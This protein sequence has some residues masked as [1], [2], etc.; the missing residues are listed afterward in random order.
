MRVIETIAELREWRR[1]VGQ[2]DV[3]FVPTMGAL[4]DGHRSL[5]KL[6]RD[7]AD[8]LAVSI[9]VN[10]LQF[11]PNE[12]LAKYPRTLEADLDACRAEGVDLV[13]APSVEEMYG[14]VRL[15][16]VGAGRMG[17]ILE[18]ASRPGHFDGVLT[19]VAKL[20]NLVKPDFAVFGQ[21]DAQQLACIRRMV[22]DLNFD[23]DIVAAPII[24]DPDGLAMSSRNRYLSPD[25]R[26][27]A[28]TLARALAAGAAQQTPAEILK[29]A[30][31]VLEQAGS[32]IEVDYLK[33]VKASTFDDVRDQ[34][35]T[36]ALLL[37]AARVGSTRLIDNHRLSAR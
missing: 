18:G 19:V 16:T 27:L 20:F 21:K 23:L 1:A 33:L 13:F 4:H 14:P 10:P 5:M 7:R 25:E 11:G 29:A 28:L 22:A 24:R 30:H 34:L 32:K 26:T 3:G 35:D 15:I 17:T 31:T 9:F 37:V 2:A 6:A 36:D 12:D 8:Q